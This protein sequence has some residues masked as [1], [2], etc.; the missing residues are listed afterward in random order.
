MMSV[1]PSGAPALAP[2][3]T[4]ADAVEGWIGQVEAESGSGDKDDGTELSDQPPV[5]AHER[6]R[7][8]KSRPALELA[9]GAIKELYPNGVP[10]QTTERNT[11]LCGKVGDWLKSNKRSDVSDAT[12]LRAAGRR[13]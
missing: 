8:D 9:R 6:S 7:R 4:H 1:A 3:K 10:D 12:I 2:L 5:R 11:I 13:K